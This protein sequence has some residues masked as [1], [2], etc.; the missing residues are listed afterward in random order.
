MAADK[1]GSRT[2]TGLLGQQAAT[3]TAY[4]D[5]LDALSAINLP[6]L[7]IGFELDVLVPAKLTREV[8]NAI[9][10][11][12]YVEIVGCGHGGPWECPDRVNSVILDFLSHLPAPPTR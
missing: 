11:G 10:G 9:S 3:T 1:P 12:R 2:V 8:A 6:T 5:R 7:V 4:D